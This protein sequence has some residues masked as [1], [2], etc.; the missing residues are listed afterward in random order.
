[1]PIRGRGRFEA[2]S[3]STL[4]SS[5]SFP[6]SRHLS[7]SLKLRGMNANFFFDSPSTLNFGLNLAHDS[8]V[9]HGS[10]F[11]FNFSG[12]ESHMGLGLAQCPPNCNVTSPG[13]LAFSVLR[14]LRISL[15]IPCST[16][17]ARSTGTFPT[18]EARL[19][20]I[21]A[22]PYRVSSFLNIVHCSLGDPA[23]RSICM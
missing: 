17:D 23:R 12:L 6:P 7:V 19:V 20:R 16:Q 5:C 13:K 10:V 15:S 14:T 22:S 2:V 4:T 1:M 21:L 8:P 3:V 11:T 18:P 9:R